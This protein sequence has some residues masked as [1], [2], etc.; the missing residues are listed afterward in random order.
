MW[1]EQKLSDLLLLLEEHSQQSPAS[2]VSALCNEDHQLRAHLQAQPELREE[3][4][5]RLEKLR[6]LDRVI[7]PAH[8]TSPSALP[9]IPGYEI[10]DLLGRGGMGVVYRARHVELKRTVAL[11]VLLA[12][13]FGS[14]KL[15]E[16]FRAEAEAV[17]RLSHPGIVQIYGMG[18]AAG[19]PFLALEYVAGAS[20][21]QRMAGRPFEPR[22]AAQWVAKIAAAVRSRTCNKCRISPAS[23]TG[24]PAS[25]T[26]QT[27]SR[28]RPVALDDGSS[29]CCATGE[30]PDVE[31]RLFIANT[32]TL[33][34]LPNSY[35]LFGIG[36]LGRWGFC[37]RKAIEQL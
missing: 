30:L 26:G 23:A 14:R 29:F 27:F 2:S 28:K 24:V 16:R 15:L 32:H 36:V 13:P 4:E 34:K 19:V 20:L 37:D 17:A 3:L 7:A 35:G 18:E 12:G 31:F 33:G 25:T 8:Q 21:K 1:D 9:E 5:R 11:K 6:A 10:L 22:T